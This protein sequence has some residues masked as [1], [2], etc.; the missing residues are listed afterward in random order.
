MPGLALNALQNRARKSGQPFAC[1]NAELPGERLRVAIVTAGLGLGMGG[2]EKQAFYMARSLAE[3]GVDVRVCDVNTPDVYERH[4]CAMQTD[5]IARSRY[6]AVHDDHES[7]RRMQV[8]LK[9]FGTLPGLPLRMLLLI[10]GLRAFRPHVIQSVHAYTNVYSA[11]AARALGAISIGG[12]R[13]DF[14]T[15]VS[16]NGRFSGFLLTWPDALAVNSR[17]AIEEVR[18]TRMLDPNRM[19]FL[20]NAIDLGSFPERLA[21]RGPAGPFK[22]ICITRLFP[23]K[24]VDVFLRS[25]AAARTREPGFEGTVVGHGPEGARLRAL[26]AELGLLPGAVDFLG[27][28]DDIATL[29][30]QAD[31]FVFCSESEGTPNVI[32]EAM[33]SGL[34][35]ITT[36]AGD[37]ADV[38]GRAGSGYVVPF[39]DV[40]A[41][42]GAMVGLARSPGLRSRLGKAGRDYVARNQATSELAGKLLEIYAAVA[43]TSR[44]ASRNKLLRVIP[45]HQPEQQLYP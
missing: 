45:R 12:L 41:T 20:P 33:A 7:L 15:C 16:D 35:V 10:A 38:V 40:E 1:G 21:V 14:K 36:P 17:Q 37:A 32:L 24:R 5:S 2:A 4:L 9:C 44:R 29:L 34:P 28:R 11:V 13:S 19:H 43:R 6:R 31:M 18:Q 30:P 25:L 8:E 23:A 26:A 3:A 39:A 42:A 22:C 27:L